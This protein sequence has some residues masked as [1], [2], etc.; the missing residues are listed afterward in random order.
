MELREVIYNLIATADY[1]LLFYY[2]L[3][4]SRD[5]NILYPVLC[6]T[7]AS[8]EAQVGFRV[9]AFAYYVCAQFLE[10][11]GLNHDSVTI[12]VNLNIA[13]IGACPDAHCDL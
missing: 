13:C 3:D 8:R 6:L 2:I 4:A 7:S 10:G 1:T 12:A 5:F 11:R 9:R